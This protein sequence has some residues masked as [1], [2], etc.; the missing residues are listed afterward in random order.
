MT[1]TT[2]WNW[3]NITRAAWQEPAAD[4]YHLLHRWRAQ[5]RTHILDLGC[6]LGR[7]ALLFARNGFKVLAQDLSASGLRK[8]AEAARR[9]GLAIDCVEG[10][11][12]HLSLADA[13]VDAVLSYHAIYHADAA[14]LDAALEGVRRVLRPGGEAYIT[15]ISTAHPAFSADEFPPVDARVRHKREEDG[16]ILPHCFTDRADLARLFRNFSMLRVQHIED[17]IGDKPGWHYHV[18]ARRD[19]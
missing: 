7:H 2:A 15:L 12:T 11:F 18:L 9:E 10:D 1:P 8:L 14:G 19:G 4:V 17:I 16:S 13:T 3:D 5:G 6:G